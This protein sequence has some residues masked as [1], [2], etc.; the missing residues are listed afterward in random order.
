MKKTTIGIFAE[1]NDAEKFI[2]EAHTIL[3]VP[4]DDI[5]Y[6]YKDV[7]GQEKEVDTREVSGTTTAEGAEKGAKAGAVVGALGGI[8]AV[9]GV[10]PIIGPLFIAGPL[11]SAIGI[12]GALGTTAAGALTGAAAGGI[13]GALLNLGV[14][15]EKAK[16]YEDR[17]LS[18]NILVAVN[19]EDD[20]A[21]EEAMMKYGAMEVDTYVPSV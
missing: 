6:L 13:L 2:N 5:S 1:R 15:R 9:A 14:A 18:G 12:T 20:R 8:A 3:A 4:H 10:I 21:A 7:L 11:V 19:T 17:V 16:T